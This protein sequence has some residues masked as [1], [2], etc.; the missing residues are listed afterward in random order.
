MGSADG[1]REAAGGT[2]ATRAAERERL[3]V[4]VPALEAF[5]ELLKGPLE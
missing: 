3:L 4:A 1:R 5:A 2:D